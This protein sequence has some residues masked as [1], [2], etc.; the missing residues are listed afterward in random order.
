MKVTGVSLERIGKHFTYIEKVLT[1]IRVV[2]TNSDFE[3]SDI[4]RVD[5]ERTAQD[6]I[7]IAI[8]GSINE[9]VE[10]IGITAQLEK[11]QDAP[12]YYW[13]YREKFYK[14]NPTKFGK[15]E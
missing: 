10:E 7:D 8:M 12:R 3:F 4:N 6:V 14:A 13:I 11:V 5:T 9:V 15:T 1:A 2:T